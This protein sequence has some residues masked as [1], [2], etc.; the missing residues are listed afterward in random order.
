MWRCFVRDQARV[1]SVAGA[2]NSL[3]RNTNSFFKRHPSCSHLMLL[4]RAA[5]LAPLPLGR[6]FYSQTGGGLG[7]R[8]PSIE[9][10]S[11]G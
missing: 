1:P 9:H 2:G 6:I 3:F 10:L 5:S 11:T 4:P 7:P 8:A